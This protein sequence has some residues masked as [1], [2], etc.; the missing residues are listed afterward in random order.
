ML[1]DNAL[2]KSVQLT[3]ATNKSMG[4]N[5]VF[6]H[7]ERTPTVADETRLFL[8]CVMNAPSVLERKDCREII[9]LRTLWRVHT[10]IT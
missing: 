2:C 5:A 7:D 8:P 1:Y 3:P 6:F 10:Y 9:V 4:K